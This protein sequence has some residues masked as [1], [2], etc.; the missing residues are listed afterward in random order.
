MRVL[1]RAAVVVIVS[2]VR[3]QMD[4]CRRQHCR[5][6]GGGSQQ[7]GGARPAETAGDHWGNL[8]LVMKFDLH[9][10]RDLARI[11]VVRSRERVLES[12][13]EQ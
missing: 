12:R 8:S 9:L 3:R 7:R 1:D 13:E 4:V 2:V 6:D 10:T 11:G 5:H